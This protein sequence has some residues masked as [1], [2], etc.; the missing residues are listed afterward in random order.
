M[1]AD[2]E[3]PVPWSLPVTTRRFEHGDPFGTGHDIMSRLGEVASLH[4]H[5]ASPAGPDPL[6]R[7]RHGATW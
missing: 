7:R 3:H 2:S 6:G 5:V 1:A 4:H